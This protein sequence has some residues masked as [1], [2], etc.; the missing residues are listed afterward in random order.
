MP[1]TSCWCRRSVPPRTRGS[2]R[3]GSRRRAARRRC[4]PG[5]GWSRSCCCPCRSRRSCTSQ[6]SGRWGPAGPTS[7]SRPG[8]CPSS[9]RRRDPCRCSRWRSPRRSCSRRSPCCDRCRARRRGW[10]SRT[11]SGRG[12][13]HRI[14]PRARRPSCRCRAGRGAGCTSAACR[15]RCARAGTG[16]TARHPGRTGRSPPGRRGSPPGGRGCTSSA[17]SGIS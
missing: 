13:P 8:R 4:W 11:W 6:P 7:S 9:C 17:S 10:P 12:S 15:P 5:R 2:C 14:A 16:W 3:P 1:G